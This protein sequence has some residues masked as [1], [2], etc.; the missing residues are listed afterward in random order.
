[1]TLED[2]LKKIKSAK[3]DIDTLNELLNNFDLQKA[4][5]TVLKLTLNTDYAEAIMLNRKK[6]NLPFGNKS[7]GSLNYIE[8]RKVLTMLLDAVTDTLHAIELT[9]TN[10]KEEKQ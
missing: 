3:D 2:K 8:K 5:S 6:H 7:F 9:P 1:M 4:N 10:D